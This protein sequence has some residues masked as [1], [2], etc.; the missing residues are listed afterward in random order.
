[1]PLKWVHKTKILSRSILYKGWSTLNSY[2]VLYMRENGEIQIQTREIYNSGDGAAILLYNPDAQ[3]ILLIKQFRLPVYLN[4][5]S[6]GFILECCAGLL[7]SKNPKETIIKE[8]FEETG[9]LIHEVKKVYEAFATP[10]AHMEKIHYF[11]GFYNNNMKINDGGGKIEEQEEI[12]VVE[13]DYSQ[14][15]LLLEKGKIIDSKTIVLLQWAL[16]NL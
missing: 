3:K 6:D 7:D 8:V 14:I 4:H 10:G 12:E 9:F 16:I 15:P 5:N 13:F 11:V 2:K 1:M